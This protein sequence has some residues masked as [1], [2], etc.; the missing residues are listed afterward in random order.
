MRTA[1][2]PVL[3]LALAS[4]VMAE[5]LARAQTSAGARAGAA[6]RAAPGATSGAAPGAMP[7]AVSAAAPA[8]AS[9]DEPTVASDVTP[10]A[11]SVPV[12]KLRSVPLKDFPRA[13]EGKP[14][15]WDSEWRRVTTS[16]LVLAAVDGAVIL[17]AQIVP[18]LPKPWVGPVLFDNA[19]R[20]A[21]RLHSLDAR[22]WAGDTSDALLS[23]SVM[24]P[25]LI[26]SLATAWWYRG[27]AD[28]AQQM[29]L[30]DGETLS[31]T[32]AI[33][34]LSATLTGRQRP[35]VQTCGKELP[36]NTV[37]CQADSK[38]RSF[39]SG[40]TSI[41]FTS[42]ALVCSHHLNLDLFEDNPADEFSCFSAEV[43][44]AS[45]GVLRIMSDNHWTSDVL[46]GAVIGNAVGF[47]A[48]Y[49]LHY[50][51]HKRDAAPA[52]AERRDFTVHFLP[53]G[54]GAA[55]VGTW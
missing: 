10:A 25:F 52:S 44:A 18:P 8:K 3:A 4:V 39:F 51:R 9:I 45:T 14:L 2:L 11:V 42:A 13:R 21:L 26:D 17:A 46:T 35:Y 15:V 50:R 32:A 5:P 16:D 40:H 7:P 33:Q 29:A 37:E 34:G 41:T 24:G 43:A 53:T 30:I 54:L 23:V 27:S 22:G 48:P 1:P 38:D 47:G 6:P 31:I 55:A 28:V 12:R 19:A 36:G 49:L 20:N